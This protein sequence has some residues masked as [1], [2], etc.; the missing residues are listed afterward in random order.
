MVAISLGAKIGLM[1]AG[2]IILVTGMLVFILTFTWWG[3]WVDS[4]L[5]LLLFVPFGLLFMFTALIFGTKPSMPRSPGYPSPYQQYPG[6]YQAGGQYPPPPQDFEGQQKY[7]RQMYD[8]AYQSGYQQG[9][10]LGLQKATEQMY[11]NYRQPYQQYA[12]PYYQYRV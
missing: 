2:V 7:Y 1:I 6:Q 10:W 5:F 3:R 8:Q 4:I 9:Y 11:K 12:Q